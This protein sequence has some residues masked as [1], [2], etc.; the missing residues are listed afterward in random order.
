MK[1]LKHKRKF[2]K[3]ED[4]GKPKSPLTFDG[5]ESDVNGKTVWVYLCKECDKK[6]C[7]EI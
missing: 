6:R 4:C 1:K 5:Y 2:A 3:C 7:N